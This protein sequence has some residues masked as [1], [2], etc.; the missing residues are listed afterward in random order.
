MAIERGGGQ[1][2]RRYPRDVLLAAGL[3]HFLTAFV[4]DA[5]LGLDGNS[6]VAMTFHFVPGGAGVEI[7]FQF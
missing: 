4:H 5:F 7:M 1:G 6:N 3:G 2:R